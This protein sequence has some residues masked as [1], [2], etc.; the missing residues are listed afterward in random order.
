MSD[1]FAEQYISS[2]E[3]E[4]GVIFGPL[5]DA[6]PIQ[7]DLALKYPLEVGIV[8]RLKNLSE[9][10]SHP[11]ATPESIFPYYFS[12]YEVTRRH[13]ETLSQEL[14][15]P[16]R[17]LEIGCGT[18]WGSRF[19][20]DDIPDSEIVATNR[21]VNDKDEVTMDSAKSRFAT[22]GLTFDEADATSLIEHFG[23]ASFDAVVMLEVIE[24]IPHELHSKVAQEVSK[25]L[26]PGGKF[27]MSTPALEGYGQT[28]SAPQSKDHVW[29]YGNRQDIAETFSPHF[30]SI[31]VNRIV[32]SIHTH[33]FGQNAIRR[34]FYSLGV[35]KAPDSMFTQYSYE[36][37]NPLTDDKHVRG[38]DTSAWF[39][40]A[41]KGDLD[42][43][44]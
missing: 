28:E 7:R 12:N 14:G 19:L 42:T 31:Q 36:K 33:T 32:N 8:G 15:R 27:L 10:R 2:K 39:T 23:D 9:G 38:Q 30:S 16:I 3:T 11:S 18:G 24:H 21:V 17:I 5:P 40:V 35:I 43:T 4:S 29:M 44:A 37:G 6:R 26:K 13:L 34:H 25:V 1:D 41:R 22:D 20:K